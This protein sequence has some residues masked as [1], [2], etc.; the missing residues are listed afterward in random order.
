MNVLI[1]LLLIIFCI[2]SNN[3]CQII[4]IIREQPWPIKIGSLGMCCNDL[5]SSSLM[6]CVNNTI[7]LLNNNNFM[8]S[9]DNILLI[10]SAINGNG[11]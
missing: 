11:Y 3:Y 8:T 6:N 9:S 5:S 1:L 10:T 4:D 2:I 7:T